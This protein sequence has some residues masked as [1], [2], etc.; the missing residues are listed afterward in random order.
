MLDT[1][2]S[3]FGLGDF[4]RKIVKTSTSPALNGFENFLFKCELCNAEWTHRVKAVC[5]DGQN[6]LHGWSRCPR[7]GCT[8][9]SFAT[10]VVSYRLVRDI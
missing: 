6:S 9:Q 7:R 2:K 3:L 8:K 4:K 1:L 10:A 5:H